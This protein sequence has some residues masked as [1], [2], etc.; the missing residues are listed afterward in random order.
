MSSST[1]T[2][3]ED[4]E[5]VSLCET[6][7]HGA[8]IRLKSVFDRFAE[9]IPYFKCKKLNIGATN[10]GFNHVVECPDW[11]LKTLA[12]RPDNIKNQS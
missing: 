3:D 1:L 7:T 4:P 11:E 2:P 9:V 8:T 6:C 5:P 12:K 10:P